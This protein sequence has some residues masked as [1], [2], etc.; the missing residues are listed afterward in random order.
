MNRTRST[1]H[2]YGPLH[3][4]HDWEQGTAKLW[5]PGTDGSNPHARP[6]ALAKFLIHYS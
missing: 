6:T 3:G 5:C 1:C 2:D 4:A